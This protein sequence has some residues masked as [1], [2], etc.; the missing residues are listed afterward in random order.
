MGSK[1]S[2]Q[3]S[4]EGRPSILQNYTDKIPK[5]NHPRCVLETE[6]NTQW[7][8]SW[9]EWL[10]IWSSKA[11]NSLI[12]TKDYSQLYKGDNLALLKTNECSYT[13][14]EDKG[15]MHPMLL[16]L[17]TEI[18]HCIML[19]LLF[20]DLWPKRNITKTLGNLSN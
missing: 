3:C 13:L 19:R 15:K 14:K 11:V 20:I 17:K 6:Q 7:G 4:N 2:M 16:N 5:N 10:G 1:S 12:I 8:V 9:I 18:C